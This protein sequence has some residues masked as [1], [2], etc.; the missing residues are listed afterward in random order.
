MDKLKIVIGVLV[1]DAICLAVLGAWG[2]L[3]EPGRELF[4][5]MTNFICIAMLIG[6]GVLA[7][8]AAMVAARAR[9]GR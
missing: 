4:G 6:A 2:L 5:E 3:T 7:I 1:V 9:A 8:A